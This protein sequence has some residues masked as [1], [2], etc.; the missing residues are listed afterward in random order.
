MNSDTDMPLEE[1]LDT[2]LREESTPSHEALTKWLKRYPKHRDALTSFFATWAVQEESP[3]TVAIEED[4]IS[5]RLGSHALH[6]LH[7]QKPARTLLAPA[8]PRLRHQV[9]SQGESEH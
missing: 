6:L 5:H 2:I 3:K 8:H 9:A 4:S 1:L 7:K